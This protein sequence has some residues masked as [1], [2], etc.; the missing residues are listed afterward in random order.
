LNDR[1]RQ[2]DNAVTTAKSRCVDIQHRPVE[3][4]WRWGREKENLI[5]FGQKPEIPGE[6]TKTERSVRGRKFLIFD[7]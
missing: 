6:F 2:L 1:H 4:L 5:I 3:W 7:N